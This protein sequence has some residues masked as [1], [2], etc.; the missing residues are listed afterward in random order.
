MLFTKGGR[1]AI[2]QDNEWNYNMTL[3]LLFIYYYYYYYYYDL[4]IC[5]LK[6]YCIACWNV[7]S[8]TPKNQQMHG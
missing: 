5:I 3:L 1:D 7:C 4:F 6:S 8:S 2:Y